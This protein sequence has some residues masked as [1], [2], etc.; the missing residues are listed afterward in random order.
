MMMIL[1]SGEKMIG[2]RVQ[3]VARKN[4]SLAAGVGWLFVPEGRKA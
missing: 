1:C 3:M 4:C 2:R